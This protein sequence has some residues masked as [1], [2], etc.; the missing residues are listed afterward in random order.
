MSKFH[1]RRLACIC[2]MALSCTLGLLV[3]SAVRADE[4]DANLLDQARRKEKVEAQRVELEFRQALADLQRLAKSSPLIALPRLKKTCARL[5]DD[6]ALP[7]D[8]RESLKRLFKDQIRITEAEITGTADPKLSKPLSSEQRRQEKERTNERDTINQR[9][10]KIRELQNEGKTD[11]ASRSA[12]E[13]A[14]RY[15]E[16]PVLQAA[17]SAAS[18]I[19]QV[20]NTR[21][22]HL[23]RERAVVGTMHD[24]DKSSTPPG[25]EL[26][27]PKDWKERTKG[28]TVAVQLTAKEK[29]VVQALN[30]IVSVS[31]KNAKLE[32]AIEYLQTVTGQPIVLDQEGLKDAE[33][34]YDSPVTLN[35]KGITLRTAL[36]KILAEVGLT[37]VVKEEVIQVT[38]AQR[39]KE[40]MI[41]RRYYIG[42]LLAGM[43][44]LAE[45]GGFP[46]GLNLSAY[47][48]QLATQKTAGAKTLIEM[49]TTT[50]DPQ[51]WQGNGGAG[52]ITYHSATA[53]LIIKQSAEVHALLGSSGL[54]K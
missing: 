28:R 6:T 31:F 14:G 37:Y 33:A 7:K 19:D 41:V 5:E 10:K 4:P 17:K 38:S 53:S 15:P 52:T 43:G 22:A 24:I 42:D 50:V 3:A 32:D 48:Q 23:Q 46:K 12:S 1:R 26:E 25:E 39:A 16:D 49:I 29:A 36:R 18:T 45:I 35:V 13:L 40:T 21:K 11:E 9:L 47:Q 30:T 8:Q 54:I 44:P 51:S 34:S 27:Y 20:N 2:S